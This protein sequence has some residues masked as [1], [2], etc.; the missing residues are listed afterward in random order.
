MGRER[1]SKT[2]LL[3][4]ALC[5]VVV[6][7]IGA[8]SAFAGES[9][10]NFERTGKQTPIGAAS[11]DAPHASSICSFS[12]QNPEQFLP[13]GSDDFEPGRVQNWGHIPKEVRVAIGK[14]PEQPG[15]SCNGHTGF[16]AG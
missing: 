16:F 2:S 4:A 13:E 1:M 11:D 3:V 6:A 14:G 9:T 5:A 15:N 7:A 8:S 10:G 12:G